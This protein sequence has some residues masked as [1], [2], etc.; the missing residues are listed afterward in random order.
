MH[1][2]LFGLLWAV[3]AGCL[4]PPA[5]AEEFP[6]VSFMVKG[7]TVSGDNPLTDTETQ[8]ILE[9]FSGE[10]KGLERVQSAAQTLER[11][12]RE[13][14]YAF[15]RVV[16]PAQNPAGGIIRLEVLTFHMDQVTV[17]GNLHFSEGNILAGLP[18]L[19]GE[20]VINQLNLN[21]ATRL[22]NE[23]QAKQVVVVFRESRKP[24]HIDTEVRVR[25]KRP[26]QLFASLNNTGNSAT[27]HQRVSVGFQHGN[28]FDRD[29]AITMSYTTSP[30]HTQD[31]RQYG[32][33]YRAPLYSLG[34][35]LTAYHTHSDVDSGKVGEFFDVSGQGE[36]FGIAY[37][38]LLLQ[39]GDYN[40]SLELGLE[41]RLFGNEST[42]VGAPIGVDVRSRPVSLKYVG[43]WEKGWGA[44][45][46]GIGYHRNLD[47][48]KHN[49]QL[50]YT[51]NGGGRDADRG[52]DAWRF[53]ANLE[54]RLPRSWALSLDLTGQYGG[55]PLISGELFGLG[56]A[57]S[58]RGF[59]EREVAG[60]NGYQG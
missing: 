24:N 47:S 9:S 25:D 44:A 28:L 2:I 20:S 11:A 36:F 52:W 31:V 26:W 48:G 17:T 8:R 49:H 43:R 3:L 19:R 5:V 27:G 46:F 34:G 6:V 38:Q 56:G 53:S 32:I 22:V 7:F 37:R 30:G 33:F 16:L 51:A 21:L 60:D 58:V 39:R 54:W 41:D 14:G 42:F 35:S 50:A 4:V 57:Y 40:H 13:R 1:Q 10:H 55:E 23:H 29:H 18:M 45:G 59:G 12:L 15:H